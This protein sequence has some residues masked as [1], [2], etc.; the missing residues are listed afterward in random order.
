MKKR[1]VH[2][3]VLHS[4]ADLE[5]RF[6]RY[7]I[8]TDVDVREQFGIKE[9]VRSKYIP[10]G[11]LRRED[12]PGESNLSA[13]ALEENGYLFLDCGGSDAPLDQ[14]THEVNRGLPVDVM[15]SIDLLFETTDLASGYLA[16]FVR[17]ISKNDRD[18]ESVTASLVIDRRSI[19]PNTPRDLRNLVVALNELYPDDPERVQRIFV[20]AM[21]GLEWLFLERIRK[22]QAEGGIVNFNEIDLRKENFLTVDNAAVGLER[23]LVDRYSE[24]S[25]EDRERD[26]RKV[27]K[28]FWAEINKAWEKREREWHTAENCFKAVGW[29]RVTLDGSEAKINL[30]FGESKSRYFS[31][32]VRRGR[33]DIAIQFYGEGWFMVSR[34]GDA[35]N[36]DQVASYLR[37]A[38]AVKRQGWIVDPLALTKRNSTSQVRLGDGTVIDQFFFPGFCIGNSFFSN[39]GGLA[40]TALTRDEVVAAV[41]AALEGCPLA[42]I[43]KEN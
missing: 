18:G 11:L 7:L 16:P 19:Y 27:L 39:L 25:E 35:I 20:W 5:A 31:P 28:L 2:T 14:H 43:W 24:R 4:A 42:S 8:E 38:D 36:L 30:V 15:A 26:V 40:P 23:C 13:R 10:A 22:A 12:W 32:V 6:M 33:V 37:R 34:R 41:T 17:V 1:N 21:D 29:V 9:T 3:L